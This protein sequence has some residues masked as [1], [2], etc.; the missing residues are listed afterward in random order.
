M[1][2]LNINGLY[3]VRAFKDLGHDVL[4]MGTGQ[5]C[6]ILLSEFVSQ[7]KLLDILKR[8]GFNPDVILWC[9]TCQIPSVLGIEGMPSLT[10]GFSIDQYCNPWHVPYSAAFDCLLVAQKDY[11]PLFAFDQIQRP[12]RW[13]P[14]FCDPETDKDLEQERDIPVSFVGTLGGRFNK[15]R[16]PF[17]KSFKRRAPLL[18]RSGEYVPVFNRSRIVLNQSAAGEC[19]FRIFQAMACGALL[20]TEDTG[21]GLRELFRPG[22]DL[23]VYPR[24]DPAAAAAVAG[25]ALADPQSMRLALAGRD[26]VLT[27]HTVRHRAKEILQLAERMLRAGVQRKRLEHK[28]AVSYEMRNTYLFLATDEELALPKPHK[29]FYKQLA[30]KESAVIEPQ[31][32]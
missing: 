21:N 11:L 10:I 4:S 8:R 1:K 2:I 17:L 5:D 9:D 24:N 16:E 6:D 22:T 20:L 26:T 23:L 18:I 19:N 14:L 30:Q 13:F 28:K 31:D 3:F 15:E 25:A 27:R 32:R 7:K 12:V 29:E